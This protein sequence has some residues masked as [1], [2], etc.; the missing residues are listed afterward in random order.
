VTAVVSGSAGGPM[1][2][3]SGLVGTCLGVESAPIRFERTGVTW[4]VSASRLVD[5][6]ATGAMGV[7]PEAAAAA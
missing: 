3:L 7:N 4:A 6:A 2:A 1:A 5:M